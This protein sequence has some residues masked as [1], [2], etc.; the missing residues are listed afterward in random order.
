MSLQAKI[1]QLKLDAA[2]AHR[3]ANGWQR[4]INLYGEDKATQFYTHLGLNH[5]PAKSVEYDGLTL[6]R[7]PRPAEAIA[8]KGVAQAQDSNKLRLTTQL[9][10]MRQLMINDA[11]GQLADLNPADYHTLAVDVPATQRNRLRVL[12][13]D[14]FNDGRQLVQRELSVVKATD[15]SDGV[16]DF[17]ELDLLA[18]V[19]TSR[20]A[21]DTQARII[22]AASR[23][24]MLGTIGAALIT[25]TQNEISAGSVSYIDRTATGLANR[26]IS[27]GRGYEAEQRSDEWGRVEYSALLDN[28]VCGPCAAADGEEAGNQDDLTPAPNPECEGYDNC[29]CFHV[30]VQD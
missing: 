9:L 1:L 5:L 15:L 20:V 3:H 26:T 2:L 30:Y 18:D 29:R 24:A 14:T 19:A 16:D 27:L 6:R 8:V 21:N 10:A 23:L 4:L 22:A 11:L 12:L 28:N 7:Q 17:G 25:S 13:L